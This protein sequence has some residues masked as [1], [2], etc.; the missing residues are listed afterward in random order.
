MTWGKMVPD[1]AGSPL[2]F[3][4]REGRL[5]ICLVLIAFGADV[6]QCDY[7]GKTPL[8]LAEQMEHSEIADFLRGVTSD[9][10][11]LLKDSSVRNQPQYIQSLLKQNSDR[12]E[13]LGTLQQQSVNL[14]SS[15]STAASSTEALLPTNTSAAHTRRTDVFISHDWGMDEC[16]R[17]NHVRASRL[18]S[19]LKAAGLVTWFDE[20]QLVGNIPKQIADG[21]ENSD[22]I[23]ILVTRR[24]MEKVSGIDSHD[25][26]LKEFNYATN[27][28]SSEKMIPIVMESG[29]VNPKQWTG[30]LG[31]ELGAQMHFRFTDDNDLDKV[32]RNVVERIG[33]TKHT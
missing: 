7:R 18:N 24:Y 5:D 17:D 19:A 30:P 4:V 27:R 16:Q 15:L 6:S 1:M 23:I 14:I 3:A 20:E 21:I 12:I 11:E 28:K 13:R 9:A 2:H 22:S 31:F 26:C 29:M 33:K 10:Q 25:Y 32:V 8:Q